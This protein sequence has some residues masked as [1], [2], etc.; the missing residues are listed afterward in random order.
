[1]YRRSGIF[2]IIFLLLVFTIIIDIIRL[3]FSLLSGLSSIL[4][5]LILVIGICYVVYKLI[6]DKDLIN[7]VNSSFHDKKEER[8]DEILKLF[9]SRNDVIISENIKI[10]KD[11]LYKGFLDL[12]I[13]YQNEAI[14]NLDDYANLYPTTYARLKESFVK[15][16]KEN[17]KENNTFK[18]NEISSV[19]FEE[20]I[21]RIDFNKTAE[22]I[23]P[24]LSD[25]VIATKSRME[26]FAKLLINTNYGNN[27]SEYVKGHKKALIDEYRKAY[28][29]KDFIHYEKELNDL[30]SGYSSQTLMDKGYYDGLIYSSKALK[31]TKELLLEIVNKELEKELN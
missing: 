2:T 31:K 3:I 10:T 8:K 11:G 28:E 26:T 19:E 30:I 16:S 12:V 23:K 13:K 6:T 25:Y 15:I 21:N 1:M 27:N 22:V 24:Q 20:T 9:A 18:A 4:L 29:M 5:P 14:A 7:K 17:R